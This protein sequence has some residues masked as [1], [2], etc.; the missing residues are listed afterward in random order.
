MIEFSTQNDYWDAV[1]GKKT[2]TTVFQMELFRKYVDK[3]ADILD[4]GCG[5]GR[6]LNELSEQG[7][8]TLCGVDF[9]SQ[10]IRR[11]NE[12]FPHLALRHHPHAG[13]PFQDER[14]DAVILLAVLTCIPEDGAQVFL[15]DELRR[16]L[17]IGGV[18]YI[19][20]FLLN[21]DQRNRDRYERFKNVYGDYGVFKL[22]EGAILRHHTEERVRTLIAPFHCLHYEKIVYRTMNGH[23]SNGFYFLGRKT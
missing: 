5:Y 19:N 10:M 14:F 15:L 22:E 11:G 7:Y 4:V 17:K 18:I 16:V 2:F 3:K 6:T 20:D 9:S 13:L 23:R 8:T 12:R 21:Q 1:A